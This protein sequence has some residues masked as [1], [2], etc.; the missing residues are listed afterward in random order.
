M[1]G[2]DKVTHRQRD[3]VVTDL[4]LYTIVIATILVGS[5]VLDKKS[6]V[7]HAENARAYTASFQP[8]LTT[9]SELR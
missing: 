4:F 6:Q 3:G 8:Y 7:I 9:D 1:K 2:P 5:S